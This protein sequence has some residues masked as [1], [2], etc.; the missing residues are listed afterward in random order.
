[1]ELENV[2][3]ESYMADLYRN[4]AKIYDPECFKVM[5]HE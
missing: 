3:L 4:L 5:D 1:M 2:I